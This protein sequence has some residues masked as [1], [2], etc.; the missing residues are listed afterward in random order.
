[1]SAPFPTATRILAGVAT[2]LVVLGCG[3]LGAPAAPAPSPPSEDAIRASA[4]AEEGCACPDKA[5]MA[6]VRESLER[7]EERYGGADA[8]PYEIYASHAR[9]ERCFR[10]DTKDL[11]REVRA[12]RERFCSCQG[13]DCAP[14]VT[15]LGSLGERVLAASFQ[16]EDAAW[17]A[18]SGGALAGCPPDRVG[19]GPEVAS[20]AEA[21]SD[22]LC[23]CT[24]A[25]CAA[26]AFAL[27]VAEGNRYA[28]L[29]ADGDA[30]ERIRRSDEK[31]CACGLSQYLAGQGG[32]ATPSSSRGQSSCTFKRRTRTETRT[33]PTTQ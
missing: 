29:E 19:R 24:S 22:A 33:S 4:I 31:V 12:A 3:S 16:R 28:V 21:I 23:A 8:L 2:S 25:R 32:G 5:C 14:A 11:V 1:M 6:K 9:F 30:K 20:R 18:V 15:A 27:Y 13:Q 7:L 10:D 17:L 26:G